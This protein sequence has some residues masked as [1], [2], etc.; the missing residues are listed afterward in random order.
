MPTVPDLSSVD[1]MN[2]QSSATL[3]VVVPAR[4]EAEKIASTLEALIAADYPNLL[5]VAVDDRSTDATGVLMDEIAARAPE[6][7]KVIHITQSEPGWMGK[8]FAMEL[9]LR[10]TESDYVLFTDAD[11]LFSPSILRRAMAYVETSQADHLVVVPTMQFQSWGVGTV[12]GFFQILGMWATRPWRVADPKSKRDSIGM[13]AFNLLRRE[14]LETIGGLEPQKLVVL[15]DITLGRRIKAAG[16]RQR[17]A[18]APGLLLIYWAKGAR[19]LVNGMT[20]NLFSGVNFR[21]ALL[22]AS[23]LW[24]VLFCLLPVAGLAWWGTLAPALLVMLCMASAYRTLGL[25]SGIDARYGL[26]YPM[27]AVLF[28]YAMLRSMVMVWK[29]RGVVWRGTHYPLAVLRLH[30]SPF[31]WEREEKKKRAG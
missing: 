10:N 5:I 23:C 24:I 28:V 18:F 29:D 20:K 15:E 14:A 11:V 26:L 25:T 3:V 21:P 13:G 7:L 1:W 27:G 30:N 19:G 9:A 16:L 12:L 22:L 17:L 6:R 8:T 4:D 31:R 2:A